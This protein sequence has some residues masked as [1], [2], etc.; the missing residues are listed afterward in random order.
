MKQ[1]LPKGREGLVRVTK[2][3]FLTRGRMVW[4]DGADD[5]YPLGRDGELT[6]QGYT[7]EAVW[8]MSL[9]LGEFT[10]N[11]FVSVEPEQGHVV[12]ELR[13]SDTLVAEE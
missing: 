13:R 5:A 3:L 8:E 4:C 7:I 12:L 2:I 9:V 10:G 6:G 1:S 11:G